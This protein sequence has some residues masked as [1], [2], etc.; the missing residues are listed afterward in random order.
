MDA[1]QVGRQ[2]ASRA[3]AIRRRTWIMLGATLL[4]V[5][6]LL[7]WAALTALFWAVERAPDLLQ[8]AGPLLASAIEQLEAVLPGIRET[9]AQYWPGLADPEPAGVMGE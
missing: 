2:I 8:S 7:V 1:L 9:I 6:A 5:A 4:V 3:F